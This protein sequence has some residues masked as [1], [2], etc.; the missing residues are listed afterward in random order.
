MLWD[1]AQWES[2]VC[3]AYCLQNATIAIHAVK[4]QNMQ[5][6]LGRCCHFVGHFKLSALAIDGLMKNKRYLA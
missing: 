5:R 3:T 6:L 1:I 2:I 4:K